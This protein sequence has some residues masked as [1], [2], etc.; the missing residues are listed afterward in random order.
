MTLTTN[1]LPKIHNLLVFIRVKDDE[2]FA[3]RK[4]LDEEPSIAK[5]QVTVLPWTGATEDDKGAVIFFSCSRPIGESISATFKE[6]GIGAPGEASDFNVLEL[7]LA[8]DMRI[9][10]AEDTDGEA[11]ALLG[12]EE[13]QVETKDSEHAEDTPKQPSSALQEFASTIKARIAVENML[14]L[15]HEGASFSFDYCMLCVVAAWIA[16]VGL[17]TNSSVVLVAS[18]L[19]GSCV[20]FYF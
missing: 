3:V 1:A 17:L 7:A 11:D 6:R 13:N 18:M 14:E 9:K 12:D 19:V 15:M 20:I 2:I 10:P 4:I 16:L 8:K 5:E